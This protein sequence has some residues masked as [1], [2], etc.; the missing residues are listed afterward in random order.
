MRG[1]PPPTPAGIKVLAAILTLRGLRE[2][3]TH[4]KIVKELGR[5]KRAVSECLR[6]L[7]RDGWISRP[8]YR[9]GCV[10]EISLLPSR[11]VVER[12]VGI[13]RGVSKRKPQKN[14]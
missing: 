9:A 6:R 7:E 10:R 11:R 12:A 4:G 14:Q 8:A 13:G 2:V 1:I 3:P 5:G